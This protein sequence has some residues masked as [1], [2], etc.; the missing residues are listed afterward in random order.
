VPTKVHCGSYEADE[1]LKA[2]K[3]RRYRHQEGFSSTRYVKKCL[4][5]QVEYPCIFLECLDIAKLKCIVRI[6]NAF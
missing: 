2:M 6:E 1:T 3:E 4:R 5:Y